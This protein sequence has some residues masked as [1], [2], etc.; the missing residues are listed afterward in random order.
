MMPERLLTM[1]EVAMLRPIFGATL[2]YPTQ[3][4]DTND[5]NSGGADNSIT[6]FD[7]PHM[8]NQSWT[9]DFSDASVSDEDKWTFVHEK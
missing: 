7:I 4:L 1:G 9:T 3:L 8:L 2:P 5:G 6:S